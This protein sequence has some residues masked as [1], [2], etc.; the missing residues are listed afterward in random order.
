MTDQVRS[1]LHARLRRPPSPYSVPGSLPVLFFGDPATARIATVGLNPSDQEYTDGNGELL[2]RSRQ[3]FATLDSFG[4]IHRS[5][6]NDGQCDEAIQWMREYF[7]PGKPVYRW[8][9]PL[10]RVVDGLGASLS[11]GT[12]AHLDLVQEATDPTWSALGRI[13]GTEQRRLLEQDLP[14]LEWQIR[15]FP[16]RA[17]ICA[18]KTVS[19]H[20]QHR[21]DV[22]IDETGTLALIRWWVGSASVAGRRVGF[23][24][25]NIPLQ[26]ATGLGA[27]GEREL[28]MLLRQKLGN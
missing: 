1:E 6:L 4:A 19:A 23:A 17:V 5:D 22:H 16:M 15:T 3:R 14:F 2:T 18:G 25:W 7:D 26:R 28:G 10:Q 8:F 9:G 12:A 20:L 11:D 13:D 27:A 21:L 24:G